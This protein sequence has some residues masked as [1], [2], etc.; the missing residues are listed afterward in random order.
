MIG[1]MKISLCTSCSLRSAF[2]A[3]TYSGEKLCKKCFSDSI[4]SK[5][6]ET[7]NK[8]KMLRFDDRIAV[9]VSGGKDSTNLLHIL[10][11]TQK[12]QLNSS[13]IAIIVDE[14]IQNY[15]DEAL[16]IAISNCTQLGIKHK[17]VSFKDLYG[18]TL[19]EIISRRKKDKTQSSCAFCGVLRRKAI[20]YAARLVKA[21]KIATGHTLDDEVQTVLMNIFHGDLT[22]LTKGSPV[23]EVVHSCFVQKVKPFCE[24]LERESAL[25]AYVKNIRFQDKPCPYASESL[26]NDVRSMLNYMEEK[27]AGTKFT[28][29]KTIEKIRPVLEQIN[30][31]NSFME[32]NNCGEPSSSGLC[33]ACEMLNQIS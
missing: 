8:Y 32:C 27:H 9:A 24:V 15:R 2:F 1:T 19:D 31:K 25:Y 22:R 26:R 16:E 21:D 11:K 10:A 33:K 18:F 7:I 3:R 12:N 4:E 20:N 6:K 29:F 30:R 13:I 5:V 23:S 17:I 14:G 28:V